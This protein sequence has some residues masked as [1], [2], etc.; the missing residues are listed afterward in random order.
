M[1]ALK[2]GNAL[3]WPCALLIIGSAPSRALDMR[4]YERRKSPLT[5]EQAGM[6]APLPDRRDALCCRARPLV[7]HRHA[8]QRR[9][10]RAHALLS[11]TIGYIAAGGPQLWP[12]VDHPA[13]DSAGLRADVA[14]AGAPWRPL[15]HRPGRAA[16]AVLHR[17]QAG[18][19]LNLHPS[20]CRRCVERARSRARRPVRHGAEQHAA[21]PVHV[22]APTDGWRS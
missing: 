21:R 9:C 2:T 17:P 20:S 19:N 4:N 16:R 3:L 13:T 12:A 14:G 5:P 18:I 1:T 8:G 7:L 6:G 11:V 10:R 22:R 15:L